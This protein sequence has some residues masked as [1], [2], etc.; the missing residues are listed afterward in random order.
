MAG[1]S[2]G[3]QCCGFE[4]K[5][6]ATDP[7][8]VCAF[9]GKSAG[10]CASCGVGRR[11]RCFGDD[12]CPVHACLA[13]RETDSHTVPVVRNKGPCTGPNCTLY[14]ESDA[15]VLERNKKVDTGFFCDGHSAVCA[16]CGRRY[17]LEDISMCDSE[18][19]GRWMCAPCAERKV[20]CG[21]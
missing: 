9:C 1:A 3:A 10:L 19:C 7:S 8:P 6:A 16:M 18:G 14:H 17:G 5:N 21:C 13:C 11:L 20:P 12:A 4:C 15:E 2:V